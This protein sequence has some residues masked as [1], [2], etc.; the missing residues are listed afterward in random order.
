MAR[1]DLLIH[2]AAQVVTCAAPD[3]PLRGNGLAQAQVIADG[4]VAIVDGM[5]AAVGS[6]AELRAE[7]PAHEEFNAY[8]HAVCPGFVDAHTHLVFAGERIGEWEMKLRGVPYLEILAAGGGILNTMRATRSAPFQH[9]LADARRRL[10]IMLSLGTTTVEAKT[11]YGLDVE[12]EL[13]LLHVVRALA[14]SHVCDM[15]PTWLG[16]HTVPPEF[17]SDSDKYVD[18]LCTE[19]VGAVAA[20]YEG[21]PFRRNQTP[22]YCDV[23][24]EVNA[25]GVDQAR[26]VLQAGAEN[27]MSAKLHVDQFHSLGGVTLAVEVGAASA[28]HLDVTDGDELQALA[29]SPCVAVVLPA[30]NF[31][32]G[33]HT[34]ANARG[35]V[36]AG[37]V[38]ALATDLNPGSAPCYS[39]P[40]VMGLA[41][42]YQHLTP[43]EA[44]HACTINAAHAV[45]LS[46]RLGSLEVGKQA[47]LLILAGSD[48]RQIMYWLG[49]NPVDV[50]IKRGRVVRT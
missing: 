29:Q 3:E 20:W 43:A 23:Y 11:G 9:L 17:A 37:A 27:G 26:R 41:C 13:T 39:L 50:V 42:R 35:L 7:W 30:V 19:M 38:L 2:S 18:Y 47:D 33:A 12:S 6:S 44:L 34:F 1:A 32:M 4:A 5:I 16:A 36:D 15:V 24:C 31:H 48:Y 49:G 14:E 25:F 8:G 22:L 10:D 21:S 40:F 45:G 46:D 28:D